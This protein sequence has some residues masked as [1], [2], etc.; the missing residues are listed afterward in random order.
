MFRSMLS[1]PKGTVPRPGKVAPR[2]GFEPRTPRLT[3]ACSTVELSGIVTQCPK[4]P[5]K[6]QPGCGRIAPRK[7]PPFGV[8]R[9]LPIRWPSGRVVRCRLGRWWRRL[10]RCVGLAPLGA[11]P[12]GAALAERP[13]DV[14]VERGPTGRTGLRTAHAPPATDCRCSSRLRSKSPLVRFSF[15]G[16]QGFGTPSE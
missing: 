16:M 1:G 3:A 14:G 4:S 6:A 12:A 9:T 13:R 2:R 5:V 8:K 15:I 11:A 10:L 7:D